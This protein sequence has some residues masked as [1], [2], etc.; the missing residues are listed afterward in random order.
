MLRLAA[1][2]FVLAS[3]SLIFAQSPYYPDRF[4]WQRRTPARPGWTPPPSTKPSRSPSPT[5]TP[6]PR[7]SR[8]RT[9]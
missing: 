2:L 3:P 1:V 5:R 7:I 8:S 4:D 9:P 6:R